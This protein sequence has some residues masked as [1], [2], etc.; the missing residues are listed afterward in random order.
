MTGLYDVDVQNRIEMQAVMELNEKLQT[1]DIL[2][3]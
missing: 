3:V 1:I 2:Y